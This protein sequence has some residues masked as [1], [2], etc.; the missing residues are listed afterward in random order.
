MEAEIEEIENALRERLEEHNDSRKAVQE[1][2][3]CICS[4]LRRQADELEERFNADLEIKFA[5]EDARLQ[6]ALNDFRVALKT[7]DSKKA[8]DA[9]RKVKGKLFVKQF[10]RVKVESVQDGE[11]EEEELYKNNDS[12][13]DR[14]KLETVR[15]VA[16]EWAVLKEPEGLTVTSVQAGVIK[17]E[18]A[19]SLS[20]E[21]EEALRQ[22]DLEGAVTYKAC[23]WKKDDEGSKKIEWHELKNEGDGKQYTFKESKLE[24]EEAYCVSVKGLCKGVETHEAKA[25]FTTPMFS[26]ICAWKECPDNVDGKMKYCVDEKNPRITTKINGNGWST[27]IGN[28]PLPH[29]K[30]TSWNI[31]ILKSEY[32]NG[33]DI[34]IGVAPSGINQNEYN[35]FKCGWYFYCWNSTLRS[36]PPHSYSYPGKEYGP[37]KCFGEYVHTG[38]SVGV[39]MDTAKGELSFVV[40]GVNLGIAYDRI[41]LDKPLVPCVILVCQG[42]SVELIA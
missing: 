41:P 10:Y 42:D 7:N 23:L 4:E 1:K 13:T 5:T 6:S 17:V 26:E 28:T 9:I 11:E 39:V 19:G 21:T 14:Y 2:I 8:A 33:Y 25:E 32:N 37:R 38:D 29:N 40:N 16:T 20:P 35:C 18:F 12:L 3:H 22:S 31:K 36:G 27:I 34:Y 30:V 24:A 15:N